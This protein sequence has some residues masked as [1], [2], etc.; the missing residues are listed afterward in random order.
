LIAHAHTHIPVG[1]DFLILF[2]SWLR[3]HFG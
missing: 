2:S 1:F 3:L